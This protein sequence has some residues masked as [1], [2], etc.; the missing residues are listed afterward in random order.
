MGAVFNANQVVAA[1]LRVARNEHGWTQTDLADALHQLTGRP[2]TKA[3]ISAMERSATGGKTRLFDAHEILEFASLLHRPM[4]WFLTPADDHDDQV[5]DL[6]DGQ[7]GSQY[8]H[9][10]FGTLPDDH[11]NARDVAQTSLTAAI[12]DTEHALARLKSTLSTVNG[13]AKQ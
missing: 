6:G 1:N 13:T 8:I 11:Q 9:Y 10:V 7:P 3:T 2:H 4:T 12:V 5:L